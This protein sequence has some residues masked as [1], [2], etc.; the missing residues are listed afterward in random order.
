MARLIRWYL[1]LLIIAAFYRDAQSQAA[2]LRIH[3][4]LYNYADIPRGAL[5][6]AEQEAAKIFKRIGI[7]TEWQVC[8]LPEE[9]F[10]RNS[11]CE[12]PESASRF[13]MRL[14]SNTMAER[15]RSGGDFFGLAS[16]P[17][18][19]GFGV[20]ASIFAERA[21]KMAGNPEW[22][23]VILGDL[24]VHELGHL[25]LSSP[26]HSVAG[27]MTGRWQTKE[28]ERAAQG[29]L[30]FLPEQAQTIRAQVLARM[31]DSGTLPANR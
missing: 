8:P 9:R 10:S 13:T 3:I 27:I 17:A 23:G 7:Q 21:T 18:G 5:V 19:G 31:I 12:S 24:M 28:L 25:L 4:H 26:A 20:R 14:L 29:A 15:L 11:A 6:Q 30:W 1:L 22:S 2:N 16:L